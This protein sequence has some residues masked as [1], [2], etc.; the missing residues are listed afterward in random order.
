MASVPPGGEALELVFDDQRAVVVEV[1]GGLRRYGAG[2]RQV[3]DGYA[4]DEVCPGGAGAVLLPWPN[5]VRDGRWEYRGAPQQLAL[6]EPSQGNAIHGLA[7]WAQWTLRRI[8]AAAATAAVR[9][10]PQP[11][12]PATLDVGV[13]YGLDAGGLTVSLT[14]VNPGGPPA[15]LGCGFHPY[16]VIDGG[17]DTGSLTI[18]AERRLPIG[19]RSLPSGAPEPWSHAGVD[20]GLGGRALDDCF[21]GLRR[22]HGGLAH[23]LVRQAGGAITDVWMDRS[24]DWLMVFTGDTLAAP[25]RRR[26]V[27]IE[28]MSCP[29]DALRCGIG[30]RWLEAGD[31]ATYRWG[32]RP[33]VTG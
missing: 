1:G 19:E 21:T 10:H 18:P 2:G 14:A 4:A 7:R 6:T 11:G 20:L 26:A 32:I 23:V 25:R 31:S 12:W 22:D 24:L 5:R 3:L 9:L 27:A 33:P 28:P 30:L 15:P 13:V 8:D 17:V 16:V 29:P